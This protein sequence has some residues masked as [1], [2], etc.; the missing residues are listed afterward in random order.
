MPCPM[1]QLEIR[2]GSRHYRGGAIRLATSMH[3]KMQRLVFAWVELYP[4]EVP[5]PPAFGDY[6]NFG[7]LTVRFSV[8]PVSLN[9]AL[10]W[11]A[12]VAGGTPTVPGLAHLRLE[13]VTLAPEPDWGR[14]AVGAEVPFEPSWHGGARLHRLVS[15][16]DSAGVNDGLTPG[17][18]GE[19]RWEDA[20]AWIAQRLHFDVL[21]SDEWRRGCALLAPNPVSRRLHHHILDRSPAGA[22]TFRITAYLRA[23][24]DPADLSIRIVERRF[25]GVVDESVHR[26][27]R[28]GSVELRFPQRVD[29]LGYDLLSD[30]QGL[31]AHHA[32][33]P[34]FRKAFV[35][36]TLTEGRVAVEVPSPRR[37]GRPTTY[38][39]DIAQPVGTTVV[40]SLPDADPTTRL[41]ELRQRSDRRTG[42][43]REGGGVGLPEAFVFYGDREEAAGT[44][45]TLLSGARRIVTFVDP[46]FDEVALRDFAMSIP[47]RNAEIR[48]LTEYRAERR[49]LD[50]NEVRMDVLAREVDAA[51]ALLTDRSLGSLEVRVTGGGVRKYH[52]RF[53]PIDDDVWH[54]GHSFNQVGR[55]DVSAMT[56]LRRPEDVK[57]M[58]DA[59]FQAA[60]AFKDAHRFWLQREPPLPSKIMR[61]VVQ[62]G[63]RLLARLEGKS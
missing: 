38:E 40:G 2:D 11:Y 41:R 20:R 39:R 48:V 42:S 37:G 5:L 60:R 35:N 12:E 47:V 4:H 16:A 51:T 14:W 9:A 28:F 19:G 32:P 43:A 45:R 8:T 1:A 13:D 46:F 62:V 24:A 57:A 21:A 26:L 22:E 61:G 49:D 36:T 30:R 54:C 25:D 50:G 44:I 6:Q 63:R 7:D 55:E 31:L 18:E 29:Q 33:R 53:L 23:G 3:R 56:R 10:N 59:D 34:L 52:D 15:M 27:D 17:V 58:I